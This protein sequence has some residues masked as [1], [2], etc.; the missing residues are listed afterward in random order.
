MIYIYGSIDKCVYIV[1]N[2]SLGS[3][4]YPE[5]IEYGKSG[6]IGFVKTYVTGRWGR[7]LC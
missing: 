3:L 2:L 4:L 7:Q 5:H 1:S 6:Y